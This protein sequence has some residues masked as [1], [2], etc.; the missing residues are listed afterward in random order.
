MAPL[1]GYDDK[2]D[3]T[4]ARIICVVVAVTCNDAYRIKPEARD[5]L[6]AFVGNII[7]SQ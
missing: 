5:G 4:V 7:R 1:Y 2:I 3:L 6:S